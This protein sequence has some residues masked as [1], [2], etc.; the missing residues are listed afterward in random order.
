[1]KEQNI[2]NRTFILG[3]IGSSLAFISI[4]IILYVIFGVGTFR[5]YNP[6]LI[7]LSILFILSSF[8]LGIIGLIKAKK[9]LLGKSLCAF[10]ILLFCLLVIFVIWIL[11]EIAYP[12]KLS[13]KMDLQRTSKII[14]ID[15]SS[16][17]YLKR[18]ETHCGPQ[19][20]GD[21]YASIQFSEKDNIFES[22]KN[23]SHWKNDVLPKS[24]E[25]LLYDDEP[26]DIFHFI[27]DPKMVFPRTNNYYYF[28]KNRSAE[29]EAPE[30]RNPDNLLNWEYSLNFTVALFDL[31]TNI[32]YIYELDT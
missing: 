21:Y 5:K 32:L 14:E 24:L 2:K 1:M 27:N 9:G 28:F 13:K 18:I 8:I 29:F 6:F 25:Y 20:D 7:N 10:P 31:N 3:L 22:I 11:I 19:Y 12:H 17:K 23:N 30:D 15:V 4:T 16:G 26:E